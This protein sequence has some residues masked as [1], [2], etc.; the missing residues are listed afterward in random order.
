MKNTI[1]Q[2]SK[3]KL[4]V[5]ILFLALQFNGCKSSFYNDSLLFDYNKSILK[6]NN[7]NDVFFKLDSSTD[8]ILL[9]KFDSYLERP[10]NFKGIKRIQYLFVSNK[11]MNESEYMEDFKIIKFTNYSEKNVIS[12]SYHVYNVNMKLV[13]QSIKSK[14]KLVCNDECLSFFEDSWTSNFNIDI[15][16]ENSII[17]TELNED[18]PHWK[19]LYCK[20]INILSNIEFK[21]YDRPK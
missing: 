15:K 19:I 21:D 9:E 10:K 3:L 5:F 7:E 6:T 4:L 2:F 20:L 17:K 14:S 11:K 8:F 12:K 13:L 16:F 18:E 1:E